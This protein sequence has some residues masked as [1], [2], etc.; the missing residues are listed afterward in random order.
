M[1]SGRVD[2]IIF[3]MLERLE[4]RPRAEAQEATQSR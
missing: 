1:S 3:D 4:W 2:E